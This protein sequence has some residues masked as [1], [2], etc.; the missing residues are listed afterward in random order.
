MAP[1]DGGRD[2]K[3]QAEVS[4]RS[5]V[6]IIVSSGTW[7]D[8]PRV[9]WEASPDKIASLYV[10]EIEDGI[11]GTSIK[12]GILKAASDEGG[13]KPQEEV[14]L[15][16]VSRASNQTGVPIMTHTWAPDRVGEEQVRVFQE[17][18]VDMRRVCIGHSNDT[19]DMEYLIGLLEQGVWLGM[20]RNPQWDSH[21]PTSEQRTRVVKALMDAGWGR[22]ILLGHDWDS[23]VGLDPPEL[24][25]EKEAYN[26][27]GYLFITRRVL[28]ML[29]SFGVA[30][31]DIEMLM[32]G[33]PRPLFRG[34]RLSA[35]QL[36]RRSPPTDDRSSR[37]EAG[38]LVSREACL[39]MGR[40]VLPNAFYILCGAHTDPSRSAQNR[41]CPDPPTRPT[42]VLLGVP[43]SPPPRGQCPF[44]TRT[45][46]PILISMTFC[47][48]LGQ[49]LASLVYLPPI[50][51]SVT[52]KLPSLS[53]A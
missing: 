38:G 37:V 32:V 39:R 17:E 14:V 10:R 3:L 35:S 2:V 41:P 40:I 48:K 46:S 51:H 20:D 45:R 9:F 28:P 43:P 1:H 47:A 15:R 42:V 53:A 24:R 8:V 12:A 22:R 50:S 4:R 31:S 36:C 19:T 26:P 13:V 52:Y 30:E 27:D 34:T 25:A 7:L 16:A 49:V 44:G 33:N 29:R 23:S 21:V 5:G 6:N 18:G 11:D